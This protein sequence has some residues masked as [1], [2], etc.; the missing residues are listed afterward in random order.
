M[1][2]KEC[3]SS[4]SKEKSLSAPPDVDGVANFDIAGISIAIELLFYQV[5]SLSF[6]SLITTAMST[7][8]NGEQRCRKKERRVRGSCLRVIFMTPSL[9]IAADSLV[10][11]W[12]EWG[13]E[14]NRRIDDKHMC[15]IRYLLCFFVADFFVFPVCVCVCVISR[16]DSGEGESV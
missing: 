11:E 15:V 7:A 6:F 12:K 10:C 16:T 14:E 9:P 5:C 8:C 4:G 13:R 2:E 3:S 1:R